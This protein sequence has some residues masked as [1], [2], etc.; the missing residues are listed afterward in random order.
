MVKTGEEVEIIGMGAATR[1]V[2]VTGVEMFQKTLDQGQAGDNVGC[3][4]AASSATDIERGQVL[5]KP[6]SITPH[7][8]FMARGV[9]ADQGRGRAAHAVLQGLPA[10]VLHPH[11]GRDGRDRAARG[12]W[13][14]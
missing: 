9:R 13:R 3:C 14:W 2:V 11:H 12:A 4:C 1:K 6:G 7:T 5:A 10:A 8:K